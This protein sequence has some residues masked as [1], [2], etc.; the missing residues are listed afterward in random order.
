MKLICLGS[1]LLL[2]YLCLIP[3][4]AQSSIND[5]FP[6]DLGPSSSNYG[7]VG[8]MEMPT[9]R[10]MKE[11]SLKLGISSS[12][13]IEYTYIV[14]TPF[15][16]LETTYR[17]SEIKD[18]KYGPFAYSGNQ[19][20]KDKGFDLK[21]KLLDETFYVPQLSLGIRDIAGTGFFSGE[22]LVGSKEIG[23]FDVS[24]G[25]GWGTLGVAG[26]IK[27]PFLDIHDGFKTRQK[28]YGEGGTFNF[29]QWFSGERASVYGG[30]EYYLFRHGLTFKLEYDTSHDGNTLGPIHP[31]VHPVESRYNFGITRPL[32]KWL[33]LGLSYE[34]GNE[35][36]VSFS[37]K[38]NYGRGGFVPK[39]DP[40]KNVV[41]LSR[42]QKSNILKNKQIFYSSLNKNL[43]E[44]NIY[45]QGASLNKKSAEIVIAQSRFRSSPRAVGRTARIVAALSPD[46][47]DKLQIVV[48]NGDIGVSSFSISRDEFNS[49]IN[50]LSSPS[51]LLTKTELQTVGDDTPSVLT[52]DFKPSVNFPE[53][54]WN[55]TPAL[56]HQIGGPEAFYLGQLWWRIDTSIKF[57]RNLT[58]H[59]SLGFDIYNTFN[60]FA[61]PSQSTIPRVRSDIQEYLS[62][63]KNNIAR[64]KIDYMWSPRK[65]LFA[66][67]DLGYL[68]E[69][70]GG[71]GGEI[72][73]RPFN[74]QFSTSLSLHHVKQ[75]SYD[76][77]FGFK[78][79]STETGFLGLYYDFPYQVQS[80]FLLGKYL[81]GD[82]GATLDL[83]RRFHNGFTLGVFATK[84]NL[85]AEE[86]GEGSFDKGFYFSI[87]VDLF[88]TKYQT[89][90]IS[91]G[92]HPLTKDGGAMLNHN[93]SLYAV[94]GDTNKSSILRDW[95]D[96]L[97]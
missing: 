34:R 23:N 35:L 95:N 86:F 50:N 90:D 82:I 71:F 40:P 47:I 89:G 67:I 28:T 20:Y 31:E 74:K 48:M 96:I 79:Y 22:Y 69:M 2:I 80:Q 52:T 30:I 10:L 56:R 88:F 7:E 84:T 59:T 87:P 44:E 17:Y 36:R 26:N 37:F 9:A 51:E 41:R 24:L 6:Q 77:R 92:M 3:I 38:G 76:Q 91:F 62:E 1:K 29:K 70:F 39:I 72:Y 16:W 25:L 64:M 15:S 65:D 68:E 46:E 53:F 57:K 75:R 83:S 8:L 93:Q 13:P 43:A 73:Y 45:I 4:N 32:G 58:L 81:A 42:E 60:E 27:N 78:D 18:R 33:D 61:N 5:Y 54:S 12:Y 63:G 21:I 19:S 97:D 49:S 11:G 85:S 14:A 66:R 94:F 55:M